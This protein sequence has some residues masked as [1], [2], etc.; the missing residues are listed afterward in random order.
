MSARTS[1]Q[2]QQEHETFERK[3]GGEALLREQPGGLVPARIERDPAQAADQREAAGRLVGGQ[4][5]ELQPEPSPQLGR[6]I[7]TDRQI[8][9]R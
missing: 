5:F 3:N 7:Y 8:G 1:N 4:P 6:N 9:S 2:A